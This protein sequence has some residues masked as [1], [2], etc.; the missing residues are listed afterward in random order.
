MVRVRNLVV[1]LTTIRQGRGA[2]TL[3]GAGLIFIAGLIHLLLTPEHFEEA[4]YLGML[5]A[6]D[7]V[8]AA[9]AAFGIYQ[10]HRW[11]WLLGASVALGAFVS[12]IFDGTVGLPGV[13]GH[14]FLEPVGIITKA[15]EALFLGLCVFKLME[16]VRWAP[17]SSLAAALTVTGLGAAL[18]LP[19]LAADP[20]PAGDEA[21]AGKG[22][23]R[24]AG[25][26]FRWKATSPA[27]HLGDQYDLVV[28]N[29]GEEDQRARIRTVIMDHA[30]KTN[31][32]VIDEPVELAP[33]EE[34]ELT[35]LNEYGTANQFNTIIGSE[36][37][38]L[39]LAV[40]VTDAEGTE[41]A[42]FNER[43]FL[44]QEGGKKKA[45]AKAHDH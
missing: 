11:G 21:S 23:G 26:Q 29:T 15:V 20:A 42:R 4:T 34:R 1:A 7:F 24:M 33:G 16:F 27:I 12:Y 10:G 36:T 39:G 32:P 35:T 2:L 13:E 5:F 40:K 9:I 38:D 41:I 18:A 25:W 8:G 17:V 43:A 28:T 22:K 31:T 45:K 37:Q 19:A 14:H 44:I 30:N 6:A 3:V